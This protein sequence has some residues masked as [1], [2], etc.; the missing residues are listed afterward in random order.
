MFNE[1]KLPFR[2][3]DSELLLYNRDDG[4][5]AIKFQDVQ[6]EVNGLCS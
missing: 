2:V 1:F 3:Q 5:M 4:D 6:V